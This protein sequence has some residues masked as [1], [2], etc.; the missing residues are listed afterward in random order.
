MVFAALGYH[1]LRMRRRL[2]AAHC[3]EQR[4]CTAARASSVSSPPPFTRAVRCVDAGSA[5]RNEGFFA[6]VSMKDDI[7]RNCI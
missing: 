5:R 3:R 1:R 6:H 2:G 4:W 7:G